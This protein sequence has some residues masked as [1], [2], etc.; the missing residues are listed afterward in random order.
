LRN[1][2][3]EYAQ[4]GSE[5]AFGGVQES[6]EQDRLAQVPGVERPFVLEQNYPTVYAHGLKWHK[7]TAGGRIP[8]AVC[9]FVL[10]DP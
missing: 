10:M 2:V 6:F 8:A 4:G 7:R 1:A 5:S 3:A 9:N